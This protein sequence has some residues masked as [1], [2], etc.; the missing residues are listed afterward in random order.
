MAAVEDI[1]K[2]PEDSEPES[3]R[4]KVDSIVWTVTMIT[5]LISIWGAE[6]VRLGRGN[7]KE[8]HWDDIARQLNENQSVQDEAGKPITVKQCTTKVN[9]LKK[10]F[11][12]EMKSKNGTGGV[13]S[14]WQYFELLAPFLAKTPKM[15]GI[16]NGRDGSKQFNVQVDESGEGAS[17]PDERE[18][19]VN[20]EKELPSSGTESDKVKPDNT[21]TGSLSTSPQNKPAQKPL[22][23]TPEGIKGQKTKHAQ[24]KG[25]QKGKTEDAEG[26][27][28][29]KSL[30]AFTAVYAQMAQSALELQKNLTKEKL[31]LQVKLAESNADMQRKMANDR[32]DNDM[33]ILEMRLRLEAE[34]ASKRA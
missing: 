20:N 34:F 21:D 25:P 11:R 18:E 32:V 26:S 33:K 5:Q 14:T 22:L 10:T 3:K 9:A 7:M 12:E 29:A 1:T 27:A 16:P 13:N 23:K 6:Y 30:D 4:Q 28:I 15:T 31:E 2:L 8:K 17:S 19:N 24:K